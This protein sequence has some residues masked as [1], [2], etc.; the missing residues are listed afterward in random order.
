[1]IRADHTLRFD[2][3]GRLLDLPEE[4]YIQT[5]SK[6]SFTEKLTE[7]EVDPS[8]IHRVMQQLDDE[9]TYQQLQSSIHKTI[10]DESLDVVQKKVIEEFSWLAR[11]YYDILFSPSTAISERVIFPISEAESNG[12]E[13]ARFV[14]FHDE[15]GE[16]T[17]YATYIAYNGIT[18]LPKLLETKD[19]IR[20]KVMPLYGEFAKN[21]G[22]ALF[23]RKINGRYAM[24][25]R[26]DGINNHI[27][28]SDDVHTWQKSTVIQEP[29]YPWQFVQIGNCGSPIETDQGWLLLTHG[30]GPM[31]TYS[32]GVSLLDLEDPTRVLGQTREP[33]LAPNASEREG[34]VPNVLYSC[35]ALLHQDQ[36]FIP[37]A[38]ADYVSLVARVALDD[39][40]SHMV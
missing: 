39:L 14:Q 1:V 27:M 15:H 12:I 20:F 5:Y 37:Y 6:D 40:F 17:Y 29:R 36:L 21:K 32:L 24:L 34:Y 23:P 16:C 7:M 35:G 9:F 3:P 13:D 31:R 8:L 22:L 28:F 26:V 19:F 25:S 11:S 30:V 2:P 10:Q 4:V 38:R 18:I 33:L